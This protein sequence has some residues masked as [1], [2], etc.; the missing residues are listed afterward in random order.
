MYSSGGLQGS[1][2][3]VFVEV[4]DVGCYLRFNHP[5]EPLTIIRPHFEYNHAAVGQRSTVLATGT[6]ISRA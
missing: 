3:D 6:A 5:V 2:T 4:V 1:W